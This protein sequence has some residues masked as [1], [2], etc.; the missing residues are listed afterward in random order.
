LDADAK[1]ALALQFKAVA[2]TKLG[3]QIDVAARNYYLTSAQFLVKELGALE[4][5]E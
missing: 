5:P 4:P 2:L 1:N 3:E